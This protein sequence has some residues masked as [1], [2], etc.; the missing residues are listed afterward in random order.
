MLSFNIIILHD[1]AYLNFSF[2]V[3][4]AIDLPA[5]YFYSYTKVTRLGKFNHLMYPKN[6]LTHLCL[7][8]S[9][10]GRA[11]SYTLKYCV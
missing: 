7:S 9:K 3:W 1:A 11:F 2:G 5:F 6:A 10:E 4:I 8:M